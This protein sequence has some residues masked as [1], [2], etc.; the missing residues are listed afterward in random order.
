MAYR[1]KVTLAI[2]GASGFC[3]GLRL[4]ECLVQAECRVNVLI[5]QAAR[6]VAALENDLQLSGQS[7]K[8]LEYLT[9]HT[10]AKAGQ[11]TVFSDH[12]WTASI[13]SGSNTDDVMVICPCSSGTLSAIAHGASNNLIERAADVML[14]ERKPLIVVPRETPL[15]AI[16]LQNMLTL[17]QNQVVVLPASPGFYHQPK[18]VAEVID[19][20]VARVLLQMGLEQNLVAE[21][22]G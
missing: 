13:A 5:S 21:W 14:K 20:V 17:A 4:L 12:E 18:S 8:L 2:T 15:S 9:E 7:H 22:G 3:Y 19:F 10:V 1:K 16:H 11:I 6:A